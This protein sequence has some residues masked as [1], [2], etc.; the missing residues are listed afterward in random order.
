MHKIL[1]IEDDQSSRKLTGQVL[2]FAGFEVLDAVDGRAGVASAISSVPDLILCDI[3]MPELDGFGV[4]KALRENPL[5]A[6]T[7]FIFLTAMGTNNDRRQGMNGGADDYLT[8]PFNPDELVHS[9]R[10]RLEKRS[11]QIEE[12]RQRTEEVRLAM[13][14]SVPKKIWE[15]F[16]RFTTVTN[17]LASDGS[18]SGREVS[19]VDQAVAKEAASLQRMIRRLK[20]YVQLPQLYGGRFELA[21]NGPLATTGPA[22]ERA[23]REV[24]RNWDRE[25]DLAIALEPAQLPL[26]E[27][28]LVLLI[29][30][31]VDNA[32]KFS[33]RG[34]PI[35]VKGFGQRAFWSLAV[36]NRGPGM[37]VEQ[38]ERI[39]AFKQ[40]W[41]G[42]KKPQGLGLGLALAQGVARLHGCEFSLQSE[43]EATTA[44]ILIPLET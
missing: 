2:R 38:I 17:L 3:T 31:L 24:C 7:P 8:K 16:E 13:D 19:A 26:C 30:E 20:I 27:E 35:D 40:F 43:R 34:T 21:G 14:A 41:S 12:T 4:L 1:I 11:R 29:E 9:I 42:N 25:A 6:L 32:C 44:S 22:L 23:A 33:P 18:A 15:T 10:R 37:S 28:Y 5:T 39:G 36:C